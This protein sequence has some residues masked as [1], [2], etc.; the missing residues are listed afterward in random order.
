MVLCFGA[1]SDCF[2]E[3]GVESS[4]NDSGLIPLSKWPSCQ[5]GSGESLYNLKSRSGVLRFRVRGT[6]AKC[7]WVDSERHSRLTGTF[8]YYVAVA[9]EYVGPSDAEAFSA[10][11]SSQLTLLPYGHF[12]TDMSS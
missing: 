2:P 12:H 8:Y 5:G 11:V 9:K 1:I 7:N 6:S 10:V 3:R 4:R